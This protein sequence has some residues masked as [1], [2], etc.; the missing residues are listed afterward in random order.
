MFSKEGQTASLP[1]HT[2]L[3]SV[4]VTTYNRA[5]LLARCLAALLGQEGAPEYE[6]L[7]VDDGS[8]DATADLPQLD[9]PRVRYLPVAHGGRAKARNAGLA[10]AKGN[11]LV[12]V[13]SDVFVVPGFLAAHWQTLARAKGS[14]F[15]Q[16]LS[17]DVASPVDPS[18]PGVPVRDFSRAFFDTKNVA[19][20]TQLLRDAGGFSEVFTEY[21]W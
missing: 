13:D 11:V 1:V 9:H 15:S 3:L 12:Y 17:V 16:G 7:V 5:D 6:V 2:P 4:V 20:S 18:A 19:V 10:A 21:G 14:T 8:T